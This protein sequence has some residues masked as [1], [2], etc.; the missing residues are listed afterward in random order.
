MRVRVVVVLPWM[1]GSEVLLRYLWHLSKRQP[2][3]LH[4]RDPLPLQRCHGDGPTMMSALPCL[5]KC[6]FPQVSMSKSRHFVTAC[7]CRLFL[8]SAATA[9]AMSSHLDILVHNWMLGHPETFV[10]TPV[11]R[12]AVPCTTQALDRARVMLII[13][14]RSP[15]S[16]LGN[17]LETLTRL[18]SRIGDLC[19]LQPRKATVRNKQKTGHDVCALAHSAACLLRNPSLHPRRLS[20]LLRTMKLRYQQSVPLA[21]APEIQIR[22]QAQVRIRQMSLCLQPWGLQCQCSL[23]PRRSS[24]D[25][26]NRT[27]CKYY[28]PYDNHQ[29]LLSH[30]RLHLSKARPQQRK[31]LR[32]L[33]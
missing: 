2:R 17:R 29:H 26:L 9:I 31:A 5:T 21:Q 19:T 12:P 27:T 7:A 24:S 13:A 22:L 33:A 3:P 1:S 32:T 25:H 28:R 10:N 6:T 16:P 8:L 15:S 30:L 11:S 14:R 20:P 18:L 4:I 23:R